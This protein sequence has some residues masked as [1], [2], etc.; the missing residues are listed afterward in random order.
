MSSLKAPEDKLQ[1]GPS[2]TNWVQYQAVDHGEF[3][4]KILKIH[5]GIDYYS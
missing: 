5:Q 2:S 3:G 4:K 1:S